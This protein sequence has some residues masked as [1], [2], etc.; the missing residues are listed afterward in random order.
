MKKDS[1]ILTG[2][3]LLMALALPALLF[4]LVGCLEKPEAKLVDLGSEVSPDEVEFALSKA[5]HGK[6]DSS[7]QLNE[8]VDYELNLRIENEDI[9][10]VSDISQEVVAIDDDVP[11]APSVI[12]HTI[13]EITTTY[14]DGKPDTVKK[15]F[16]ID[17]KKAGDVALQSFNSPVSFLRLSSIMAMD[18]NPIRTT[19]HNL[20]VENIKVAV[21]DRVAMKPNCLG[22]ENCEMKATHITFSRADWYSDTNRDITHFNFTFS[23]DAPYLGVALNGCMNFLYRANGREYLVTQC[24]VLRDFQYTKP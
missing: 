10:K 7:M 23:T 3:H 8:K 19:F 6:P 17:V 13:D 21:P 18:A 5:T 20:L 24:Q 9:I 12:R 4:L 22:L 14:E 15:E 1:L 2:L 11:S 16:Y